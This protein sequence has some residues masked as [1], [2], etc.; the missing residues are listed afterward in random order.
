[1]PL[2]GH[3][4]KRMGYKPGRRYQ[5][6]LSALQDQVLDGKIMTMATAEAF[7]MQQFPRP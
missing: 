6:I 4:L 3:D 1:M 5:T 7:V 2:G